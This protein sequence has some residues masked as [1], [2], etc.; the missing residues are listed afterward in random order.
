M[1]KCVQTGVRHLVT[2]VTQEHFPTPR[3]VLSMHRQSDG[4]ATDNLEGTRALM[5]GDMR[6]MEMPLLRA[7]RDATAADHERLDAAFGSLDLT[8]EADFVR[9]LA[10]HAL[11][12]TPVFRRFRDSVEGMFGIAC[13]DY[14]ALVRADL[15]EHGFDTARLSPL[16][17][18]HADT[19]D[20]DVGSDMGTVYV[21]A[22]SR[23]GLAMLRKQGY[24]GSAGGAVSRYMEDRQGLEIWRALLERM[25]TRSFSPREIDAAQVAARGAFKGFARG[26]AQSGDLMATSDS[27][28]NLVSTPEVAA[29]A[30]LGNDAA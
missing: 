26:F 11:G 19:A 23:L 9:F 18:A 22:G 28:S 13:P 17:A 7:L 4:L 2:N 10:G 29:P 8:V 3:V 24:A 27:S 6:L 15:A 16:V 14:L 5:P 20:V 21:V 30:A 1:V 12:L 25:R